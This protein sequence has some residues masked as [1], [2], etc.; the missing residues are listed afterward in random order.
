VKT[1]SLFI[2]LLLFSAASIAGATTHVVKSGDNLYRIALNHGVTVSQLQNANPNVS[3]QTLRVG[4]K[5]V[6]PTGGQANVARETTAAPVAKSSPAPAPAPEPVN[7]VVASGSYEIKAGDSLSKIARE[8]GTTVAALQ[9]ANPNLNPNRM[10][11]GQK[12]NLTG[13]ASSSNTNTSAI[14]KAPTPEPTPAPAAVASA[15]A[16]KSKPAPE[17]APAPAP[18]PKKEVIAAAETKAPAPAKTIETTPLIKETTTQTIQNQPAAPEPTPVASSYRLIKTTRE[19]TLADV[20]K[21]HQTTAEKINA[22]NGW[23]FSP[24]TLLAVDSELYVPAQP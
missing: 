15:P 9:A 13:S 3:A 2:G 19:L 7:Q 10:A 11:I 24:Q 20:A 18:A 6:I 21:E 14:A 16:P 17:P 12:I 23:T 4:Q 22:L 8:Q 1:N 5:L